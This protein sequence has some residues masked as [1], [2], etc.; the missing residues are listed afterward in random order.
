M[1]NYFEK[2]MDKE[3]EDSSHRAIRNIYRIGKK[4]RIKSWLVGIVIFLIILLFLPWTQNIQNSGK[5]TT[6]QMQDRPQEINATIGGRIERWYVREGDLVK[7]GDTLISI[8][9]IKVDYLDPELLTRINQQLEAKLEG[10]ENY[11]GKVNTAEMQIRALTESQQLK[12]SQLK[13]KLEQQRLKYLSDS[14]DMIAARNE[15]NL[16]SKQYQRQQQMFDSG[17][18]SLTQLEQRNITFQNAQAKKTSTEIK[19]NNTRNEMK[20]LELEIS[21]AIQ[22]YSEKISKITGDKYQSQYEIASGQSEVA[23][24]R[25]QYASYDLRSK[26]YNIIAPQDGQVVNAKKA[27][28]G[29]ILK[30]G[31]LILDIVPAN[32]NLCVELFVEPMDMPLVQ[33]GEKVRFAF[34]G[35]P[36]VV[37]SG[38]PSASY[39][40]FGGVVAAIESNIGANGKFRILVKEDPADRKWPPALRIGSGAQAMMLL[41]NVPIWY[42]LWRNIN[43]FPPDFYQVENSDTK[44][45]KDKKGQ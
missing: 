30:D 7:K 12:I 35:F 21:S 10:I 2:D 23:K 39:G 15:W 36:A 40:T 4:S 27:G 1:Q 8:S 13:N 25:N 9:E 24:L 26:M 45:A 6:L 28:I 33:I 11:K 42:E 38:W 20:V 43:G 32:R 37:F 14:M 3:A 17:L 34:D 16:A 29:E 22:D 31:E 41:R 19:W 5:V 18:V 44:A